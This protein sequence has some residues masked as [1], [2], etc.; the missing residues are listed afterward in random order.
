MW[1]ALREVDHGSS[2]DLAAAPRCQ[3]AASRVAALVIFVQ[4]A[5][6]TRLRARQCMRIK[7][8]S[9]KFSSTSLDAVPVYS[10]NPWDPGTACI[11]LD[12]NSDTST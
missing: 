11:Q 3:F 9:E 12:V 1:I 7:T 8:Q 6:V 10:R 2:V 5:A 4:P